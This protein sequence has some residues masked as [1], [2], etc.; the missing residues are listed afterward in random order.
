MPSSQW[1]HLSQPHTSHL[2][3]MWMCVE[4]GKC[5]LIDL[6][7][8]YD[9]VSI[10]LY[11]IGKGFA[12]VMKRH[13]MSGMPASHGVTKAHRKMG[14]T[15]GGQDPGRIWPGK[16]MA[17]RMGGKR[18]TAQCLKVHTR[19]LTCTHHCHGNDDVY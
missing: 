16:R 14:G 6:V 15:G 9:P 7:S 19:S 10:S 5:E 11:S 3:S 13:G 12:G 4:R 17:G 18:T 1:A 8:E 2:A